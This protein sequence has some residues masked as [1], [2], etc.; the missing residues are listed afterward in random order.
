MIMTQVKK[1]SQWQNIHRLYKTAFPKCERKPF[2]LIWFVHQKGN[3]DVWVMETEEGFTGFAITLNVRDMV[4]LDYFAV[5]DSW[6]GKGFGGQA[7]RQL[8]KHYSDRRFF[9]EIESVYHAAENL[10]ERQR[11]KRFYLQNGMTEM[12][13]MADVFG[14]PMELL[15]YKCR[16]NFRE[17]QSLYQESFGKWALKHLTAL[18]YPNAE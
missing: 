8:Q 9:L 12:S 5:S 15:G 7:L 3:A 16:V 2:A 4:L 17:Y 6:R 11:R 13:V 18:P 14:T 1:L 10:A